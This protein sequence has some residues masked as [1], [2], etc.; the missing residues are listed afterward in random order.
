MA[1]VSKR[2]GEFTFLCICSQMHFS[3]CLYPLSRFECPILSLI[4]SAAPPLHWI[5]YTYPTELAFSAWRILSSMPQ[6]WIGPLLHSG[7]DVTDCKQQWSLCLV[8]GTV[9]TDMDN[10]LSKHK[11]SRTA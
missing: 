10:M 3:F 1:P 6:K 5:L 11:H 2:M 4:A 8:E 7:P 9:H